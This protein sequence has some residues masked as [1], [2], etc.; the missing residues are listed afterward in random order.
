MHN[1]LECSELGVENYSEFL[2]IQR[3]HVGVE[4]N[5]TN[6]HSKHGKGQK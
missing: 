1:I 4:N 6:S 2:E 5:S 3:F